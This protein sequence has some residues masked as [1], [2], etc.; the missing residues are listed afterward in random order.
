MRRLR[1]AAAQRRPA[2]RECCGLLCLLGLGKWGKWVSEAGIG[3]VEKSP[4]TCFTTFTGF[5]RPG[6]CTH[7]S[8]GGGESKIP[9]HKVPQPSMPT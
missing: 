1:T 4:L 2:V 9:L 3:S 8:I 5:Q 6:S 7:R